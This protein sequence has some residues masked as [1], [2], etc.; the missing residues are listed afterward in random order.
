M[1]KSTRSTLSI[2]SIT[3]VWF[4]CWFGQPTTTAWADQI[5][6]INGSAGGKKFDGIGAVSGGGATSVLLKDYPEPQRSQVLDLLFKPK[7]GASM[8]ALLVEVPGRWKLDSGFRAE[9]HAYA[10]RSESLS[11]IRVVDN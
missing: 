3:S 8:S 4:C 11:R 6:E 7:F 5:V 10:R 9:S 1:G 2:V